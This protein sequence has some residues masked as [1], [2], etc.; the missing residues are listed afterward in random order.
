MPGRRRLVQA[1]RFATH[2]AGL[3]NSS[4][5]IK[6]SFVAYC[7]G[8]Q[9]E[10]E[11]ERERESR[12]AYTHRADASQC[13]KVPERHRPSVER[14]WHCDQLQDALRSVK[15]PAPAP[16][17]TGSIGTVPSPGSCTAWSYRNRSTAARDTA[18]WCWI[19]SH[20]APSILASNLVLIGFKKHTTL[21]FDRPPDL[22]LQARGR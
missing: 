20:E 18:I 14:R 7:N 2:T 6:F 9:R 19:E 15:T 13:L 10:R 5:L 1:S 17:E 22:L 11:R 4:S 3:R 12:R 21:L 16:S 8:V